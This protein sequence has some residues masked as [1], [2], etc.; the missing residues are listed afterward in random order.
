M[1]LVEFLIKLLEAQAQT[2]S[3]LAALLGEEQL[4]EI[5]ESQSDTPEKD[6]SPLSNKLSSLFASDPR[7]GASHIYAE[8]AG[9]VREW[10]LPAMLEFHLWAYPHYRAF[11]ESELDLNA[12]LRMSGENTEDPG[13]LLV[14]EAVKEASLWMK[15]LP[16]KPEIGRQAELAAQ[17]PWLRFRT[18]VMKRMGRRPLGAIT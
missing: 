6:S 1:R 16:L 2:L 3:R 17:V 9:A 7:G 8:L 13:V 10:N 15:R 11:V 12:R 5:L 14:D 18:E 4:I